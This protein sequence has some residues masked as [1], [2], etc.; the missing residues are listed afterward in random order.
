MLYIMCPP[1]LRNTPMW[2]PTW[3]IRF[4]V[5]VDLDP[6]LLRTSNLFYR[7]KKNIED[8]RIESR[9]SHATRLSAMSS[10]VSLIGYKDILLSLLSEC[11]RTQLFLPSYD[12]LYLCHWISVEAPLLV[13]VGNWIDLA[14]FGCLQMMESKGMRGGFPLLKK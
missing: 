5:W 11:I 6:F 2:R 1:S 8:A 12:R 14:T 13:G 9:H 3:F 10:L 4:T 7:L